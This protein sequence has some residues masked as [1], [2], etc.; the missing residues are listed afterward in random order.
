MKETLVI[1][2]L[3]E[4]KSILSD[5]LMINRRSNRAKIS[6]LMINLT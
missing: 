4:L 1:F 3:A 5:G 6:V 2:I